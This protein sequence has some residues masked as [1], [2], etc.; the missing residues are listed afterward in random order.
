MTASSWRKSKKA[1]WGRLPPA[2]RDAL[3]AVLFE[4]YGL[5]KAAF[6]GIEFLR[7]KSNL[8]FGTSEAVEFH[9]QGSL[10]I[11][12]S[13]GRFDGQVF[14]LSAE[15]ARCMGHD[16]VKHVRFLAPKE[17]M[18]YLGGEDLQWPSGN[19]PVHAVILKSR[20]RVLGTG[21]V[22]DGRLK[23]LLPVSLRDW[24]AD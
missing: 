14:K 22:R 11:G 19:K 21:L 9:D 8:R 5:P 2:E 24:T 23:N 1:R 13:L 7:Q 17:I 16:A 6:D 18:R 12:L 4:T 10:R 20:F 3:I 15:A